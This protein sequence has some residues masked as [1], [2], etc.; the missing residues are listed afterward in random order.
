MARVIVSAGHTQNEPGAVAGE[1]REVDLTRK[2]VGKI[3][4]IL[5]N[6]GIITL[7]VPPELELAQRTDWINNTGYKEETED[8]CL[9]IHINDGGK[10]GLEGW[11]KNKGAN[12]SQ[13]LTKNIIEESCKTTGLKNQGIK[14][15]FDHQLKTLSF[16]H[17][18]NPTS[19]LIECL[20]ID[21]PEDQK[22]LKD[23]SKIELLAK[24]IVNGIIIFFKIEP[25]NKTNI[26]AEPTAQ[27]FSTPSY[28]PPS[29]LPYTSQT[30][31]YKPYMPY[32]PQPSYGYG[33]TPGAFGNQPQDREQ[34]KKMV[35]TKYQ[36]VLG[37]K[38]S[39]QDLD[40]FINLGLSEEQM[41]KRLVE[42][43]DH[44][45]LVEDSQEYKKIKPIYDKLKVKEKQLEVQVKDKDAIITRQNDLINQKNKLFQK[46]NEN[47]LIVNHTDHEQVPSMQINPN[48][49]QTK[50]ATFINKIL[51]KL[52]DIFD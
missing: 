30:P 17:N 37:K 26:T 25:K 18:T 22:F 10:S 28:N 11:F 27:P 52:N 45:Y 24:G 46:S 16:L 15:E 41:T 49:H 6:E 1:L 8:I 51:Q 7:S 19:S 33:S 40:Y 32:S 2:I 3:I 29:P 21:N 12:K 4:Y 38:V 42:S 23:E 43:Q 34:R 31:S 36:Q 20:Y 14:S 50:K 5:R 48:Q 9:E 47:P 39:D 13:E 44:A 35:K